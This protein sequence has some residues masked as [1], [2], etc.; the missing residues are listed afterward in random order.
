[1]YLDLDRN[2]QGRY[3]LDVAT[4]LVLDWQEEDERAIALRGRLVVDHLRDRILVTGSLAGEIRETCD[5]CLESFILELE[6]PV[7]ILILRDT[8]L[9]E[10]QDTC[11]IHQKTGEVDLK[12]PLRELALLAV[13]Q[14]KLCSKVC[15]GICPHC[16][17][18]LNQRECDCL[19][20]EYDPRWN[21]LPPADT[22]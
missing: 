4:R 9:D 18:N 14:K 6:V 3:P 16:G 13:P 11:V 19:D 20:E 21:D 17:V 10:E 5:R 8:D 15:R 12:P 2:R 7:E 22:S 1:M